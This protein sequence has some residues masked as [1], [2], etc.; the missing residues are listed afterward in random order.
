[1]SYNETSGYYD[2]YFDVSSLPTGYHHWLV[3]IATDL[4]GEQ[5]TVSEEIEFTV[6]GGIVD[7]VGGDPPEWDPDASVLP[8][9]V[10]SYIDDDN[11]LDYEEEV[12]D[13]YFKVV[14]SDEI[15]IAVVDF[16]VYALDDFDNS[17]GEFELSDARVELTESLS[18]SGSDGDWL[19]YEYTWDST[20]SL[21]KF[22]LCKFEIQD[23]DTITNR[24]IIRI[25]LEIDNILDAQ[26]DTE[27]T[28]PG[29]E[30]EIILLALSSLVLI[31]PLIKRKYRNKSH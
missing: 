24:L 6:I 9:N 13:V 30:V 7:I 16:T 15:G 17:T 22:Y 8:E 5:H 4:D 25:V 2:I 18:Q 26:L 14:V 23:E 11:L 28:T 19:I 21:D 27:Y 12:G 29:F 1:M 31:I 3:V 20:S 10:S